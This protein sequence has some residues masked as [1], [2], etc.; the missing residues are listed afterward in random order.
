MTEKEKILNHEIYN[1]NYD[2][3][4]ELDRVRVKD[5]CYTYNNLLPSYREEQ[6]QIIKE[7]IG[8]TK[9]NIW[10]EAPFMCDYGYN[11]EV[12]DNF[13][14]NHGLIIL[15]AGGIKFGDNVFIRP[16]CGF[17]TSS[18]PLDYTI[19]NKGL[20]TA[21]SIIVGD[22]VWIGGN[23]TVLPGVTIGS[24]VVIGA[25]SVVV[26]DIPNNSLA[27]GNPAKVIKKLTDKEII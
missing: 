10:I 1:A 11:I 22:N 4:L 5:L 2:E 23:V 14:A 16:T 26:K 25:G 9:E 24:N 18:H 20:E 15:D 12:G 19:R 6:K 13:Y 7:I 17:Y 8:K 21:E 3:E 27:V